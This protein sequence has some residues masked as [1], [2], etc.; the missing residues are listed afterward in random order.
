MSKKK[1]EPVLEPSPDQPVLQKPKKHPIVFTVLILCAAGLGFIGYQK[2]QRNT[3][4]S[5]PVDEKAVVSEAVIL[6]MP[7]VV[8]DPVTKK[9]V[10]APLK[11]VVTEEIILPESDHIMETPAP[12]IEMSKPEIETPAPKIETPASLH[13]EQHA[14][15]EPVVAQKPDNRTV[16]LNLYN[17]F[18]LGRS[19]EETFR[20]AVPFLSIDLQKG[21]TRFCLNDNTV[22]TDLI[23]HF[24]TCKKKA[25]RTYHLTADPSWKGKIKAGLA[26]LVDVHRLKPTGTDVPAVLD[27]AQNALTDKNVEESVRLID[28]LPDAVQTDFIPFVKEADFFINTQNELVHA[29][30]QGVQ[31]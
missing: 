10:P 5:L 31:P 12:E 22:F 15:V 28:T 26:H 29:L 14:A 23:N 17:D 3:L 11:P 25:M 13:S 9:M 6:P 27:L 16:L 4:P 7:E 18:I 2:T 30:T 24:K 19:C 20:E 21:L 1:N 8:F